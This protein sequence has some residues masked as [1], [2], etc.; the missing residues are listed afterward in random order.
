MFGRKRKEDDGP[1]K[2]NLVNI[3]FN[4]FLKEN[5]HYTVA[6]RVNG[7]ILVKKIARWAY[8]DVRG[9][10]VQACF[11]IETDKGVYCFQVK[12]QELML[13]NTDVCTSLY[14]NLKP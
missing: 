12:G 11:S 1:I 8:C 14:P 3:A 2:E 5:E 13:I 4:S 9:E 10:D 6:G 7:A